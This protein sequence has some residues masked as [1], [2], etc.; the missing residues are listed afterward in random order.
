MTY[1]SMRDWLFSV[2]TFAASML[3]LYIALV[4]QLPRPYWA[5]ASVYIVSNPFV[6]ATRSKALYRALGTALGAAAAITLVPPFVETPL[7][8]S[9][10]VALWTGTMLYLAISDRTARSYVFM[11]AG[12]T[13]PL[14]ALPT[15]TDPTT[16]FDVAIARTQEITLGI[17]CASVV[18]SN[19]LPSRIAPTLIERA[20]AWFRDA[21][22]YGR[23]TLSGQITGK[24]LSACRQR[25]AATVNQL[26]FLLSQLSY[27]HA[28]PEL[29]ARAQDLR[30]RMQLFLPIISA[31]A[32]PLVAL[33]RDLH[34]WPAGL[35][36]LLTDAAK[37]FDAP[38]PTRAADIHDDAGD[39]VAESLRARVAALQ[40]PHD[41]L[42]SWEGALLSNALWRLGQVI[43]VWQ[44]CRTLRALIAHEAGAWRP[45]YR[46]WR[47]GG[48]ERFYDRGLMLFSC[49]VPMG[50]ILVACWLWVSSGWHD[51]AAAVTLAAIACC[52]F[53]AL[54][55]P[56]PLVFRFFL[57]TTA[58]VVFA[59]LYLFVVLPKVHDFA[60]LVLLFAGP[61]ILIG[62]LIPRPAFNMVTMLVAVNTATFISIQ[63]AYEADFFVFLNS[64]IAGVAGLLFAY[65]WTR[66][67]RPFGAELA[68]KRLLRSSWSDVALSAG[69]GPIDD[70]RNLASR[71][72]DRLMQLIPRLAASDEH[73]HP[74]IESFRD[75][76]IALNAL[77]LRRSRR[78]LDGELP[79]AIDRVLAGVSDHY[80]RCA[81]ASARQDAPSALLA[82]IDDALHRVATRS[83]AQEAADSADAADT[84]PAG[85]TGAGAQTPPPAR[86]SQRWLRDT[87]HAL[88]GLRLSLYPALAGQRPGANPTGANG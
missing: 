79:A 6:G 88:V 4:F 59:G 38:L 42:T 41:A 14:I 50:A 5:M 84:G 12:Y 73:R 85:A 49:L 30:G 43:D 51:G 61:F 19:F 25:L 82:T 60:M 33:R 23:E 46:H 29:L 39:P 11:L 64:N 63:S 13:M 47:L 52:F 45:R 40:P 81:E 24:A 37:W 36:A 17:I 72:V 22:F 76:R 65:V 18:G 27:D 15:V 78:K 48:T 56:A 9:V 21:A 70:Q 1:P 7:L 87:L 32:D 86:F 75:L 44:D 35:D 67:T 83:L 62:T 34:T 71:M 2:K 31:L 69:A 28:H 66:A 53:A 77:D 3:A 20:D 16:I 55:E 10:I 74:S 26:E 58:S 54:D 80:A 68:A 57:A 8:F